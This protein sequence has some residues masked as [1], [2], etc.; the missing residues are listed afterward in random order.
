MSGSWVSIVST[1]NVVAIG[2]PFNNESG[3]NSG[4]ARVFDLNCIATALQKLN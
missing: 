3:N 4:N 2:A 1:E